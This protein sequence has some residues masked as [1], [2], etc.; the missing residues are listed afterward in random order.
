M[1]NYTRSRRSQR[2]GAITRKR[3]SPQTIKLTRADGT[4]TTGGTLQ[5]SRWWI[6]ISNGLLYIYRDNG[7]TYWVLSKV[8]PSMRFT[9]STRTIHIASNT[10]ILKSPTVYERVKAILSE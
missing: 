1:A 2:K 7:R 8:R 4:L 5:K 9:D 6:S 10:L 3:G